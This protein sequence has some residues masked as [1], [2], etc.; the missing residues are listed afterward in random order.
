MEQI[1]LSIDCLVLGYSEDQKVKGAFN[2]E[3]Y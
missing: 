3:N 2:Q 1:N